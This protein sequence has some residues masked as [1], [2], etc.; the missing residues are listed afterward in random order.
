MALFFIVLLLGVAN[1]GPV[2]IVS[3]NGGEPLISGKVWNVQIS[4]NYGE[5]LYKPAK[6]RLSYWCRGD[7]FLNLDESKIWKTVGVRY[8]STTTGCFPTYLWEV[9]SVQ[10]SV[11][12]IRKCKVKVQL[13]NANDEIFA[14]DQ[15]DAFFNI[16]PYVPIDNEP[17]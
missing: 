6:Y 7:D 17:L 11:G 16:N 2:A 9:P 10:R 1:A 14:K 12:D 15:S 5:V 13:F 4:I 3:P 8:C